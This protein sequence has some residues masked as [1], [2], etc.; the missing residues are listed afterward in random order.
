MH[1]NRHEEKTNRSP[2]ILRGEMDADLRRQGPVTGKYQYNVHL[3]NG[4]HSSVESGPITNHPFDAPDACSG[5]AFHLS[6]SSPL[7]SWRGIIKVCLWN[8]LA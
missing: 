3:D 2:E 8:N 5:Q 7:R 1:T 4:S 6:P